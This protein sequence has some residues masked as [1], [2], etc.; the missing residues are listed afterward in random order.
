[1]LYFPALQWIQLWCVAGLAF[2]RDPGEACGA[3]QG[4]AA[5]GCWPGPL[6]QPGMWL[7]EGQVVWRQILPSAL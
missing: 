1:M 4:P 5:P 3:G 7:P 2:L 6:L